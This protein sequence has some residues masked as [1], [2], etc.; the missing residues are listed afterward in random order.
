VSVVESLRERLAELPAL[1]P[2]AVCGHVVRDA[3]V[4]GP[5]GGLAE[6]DRD[7][8]RADGDPP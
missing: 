6:L 5:L 8:T 2:V 3:L 4:V 7:P 1:G